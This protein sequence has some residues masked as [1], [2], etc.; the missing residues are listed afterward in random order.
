M[1]FSFKICS[2]L[3]PTMDGMKPPTSSHCPYHAETG[4]ATHQPR[5][6]WPPGPPSGLT[7]WRFLRRMS[8]NLL[9]A[10][11]EWKQSHGDVVHLRIWPEHQIVL[12]DPT[13]VRELLVNH[14]D[15][16]IRWER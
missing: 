12:T 9:G 4:T 2:K 6:S 1:S 5:G 14:H 7:G 8:R 11:S 15:A 16:L 13:L 3:R 10:L